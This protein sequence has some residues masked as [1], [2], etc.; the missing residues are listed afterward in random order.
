MPAAL[1]PKNLS[2]SSSSY[3]IEWVAPGAVQASMTVWPQEFFQNWRLKVALAALYPVSIDV[4]V[5]L[6]PS[7]FVHSSID[8]SMFL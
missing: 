1:R 8:S 7:T 5:M 2:I 3:V 4:G 6:S